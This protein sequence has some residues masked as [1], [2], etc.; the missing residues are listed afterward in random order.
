VTAQRY[1][2]TAQDWRI[3]LAAARQSYDDSHGV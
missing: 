2:R 3:Q 1:R